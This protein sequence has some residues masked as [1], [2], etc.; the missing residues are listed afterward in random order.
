MFFDSLGVKWDYEPEGYDL[1]EA[2]RYLPDFFLPALDVWVEIKG[3][4][5]DADEIKKAKA[6]AAQSEQ[7]VHIFFGG[8]AEPTGQKV[9]GKTEVSG[10]TR[11]LAVGLKSNR[12]PK[13]PQKP[14]TSIW[15]QCTTCKAVG[16]IGIRLDGSPHRSICECVGPS[17][18]PMGERLLT[19]Y[20]AARSA[21]FEF[22]QSGARKAPNPKTTPIR[23]VPV[24]KPARSRPAEGPLPKWTPVDNGHRANWE[25]EA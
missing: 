19:A 9:D 3:K 14:M 16:I 5:P 1:G 10:G 15:C 7:E 2:G 25:S 8:M 22:G 20:A 13:L 11:A 12:W 17:L 18:S 21:R 23:G 4:Y 6:L 24:F